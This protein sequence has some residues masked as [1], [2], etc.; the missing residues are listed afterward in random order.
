MTSPSTFIDVQKRFAPRKEASCGK[1]VP[2]KCGCLLKLYPGTWDKVYHQV[3][4]Q[5]GNLWMCFGLSNPQVDGGTSYRIH[6]LRSRL[7][8]APT[9]APRLYHVTQDI[10]LPVQSLPTA[11][12][13]ASSNF[14]SSTHVQRP[15]AILYVGQCSPAGRWSLS[16]FCGEVKQEVDCKPYSALARLL[17]GQGEYLF[18]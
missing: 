17:E 15:S 4:H 16:V 11:L 13:Q 10:T 6:K 8:F 3:P 7:K 5:R 12:G 9:S 1:N 14:I 18:L 2:G